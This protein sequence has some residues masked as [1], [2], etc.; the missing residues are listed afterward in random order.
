MGPRLAE[1]QVAVAEHVPASQLVPTS[2]NAFTAYASRA[3]IK[4]QEADVIELA[5][6][7]AVSD[8]AVPHQ[9]TFPGGFALARAG[10]QTRVKAKSARNY[11]RT[12]DKLARC[13]GNVD[14]RSCRAAPGG[15][16]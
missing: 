7:A 1:L 10:G 16:F 15:T 11:K 9:Y 14:V 6:L 3:L 2:F 13:F 12:A 8:A 4:G 5:D